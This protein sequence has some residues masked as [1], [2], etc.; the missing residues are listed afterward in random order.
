M[1][2]KLTLGALLEELGPVLDEFAGNLS[3]LLELFRHC[4]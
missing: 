3:I 1:S 4:D 2:K